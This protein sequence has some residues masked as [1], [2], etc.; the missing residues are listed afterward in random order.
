M[1]K[2]SKMIS[3][4]PRV[5]VRLNSSSSRAAVRSDWTKEQ[6]KEIYDMPLMDLV[7]RA[8]TVH[9]QYFNSAEVQQVRI[10]SPVNYLIAERVP[11]P[12]IPSFG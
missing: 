9:R 5:C 6:I 10:L 4:I 2:T 7:F 1:Q 11:R 3:R 8:S 12:K